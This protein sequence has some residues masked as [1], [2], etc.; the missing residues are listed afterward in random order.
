M[1]K[2]KQKEQQQQKQ[3]PNPTPGLLNITSKFEPVRKP[4][5]T[6]TPAAETELNTSSDVA[7]NI[8]EMT[9]QMNDL[10]MDERQEISK[11]LKKLRKKLREIEEIESRINSGGLAKPEKDQ[12]EK[13]SKKGEILNEIQELE[14]VRKGLK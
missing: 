10:N 12:L 3:K 14:N 7:E 1:K 11:K 6:P 4:K 2:Q 13:I 9:D 8:S 5:N